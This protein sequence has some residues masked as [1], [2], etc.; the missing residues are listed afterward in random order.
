MPTDGEKLNKY[1]AQLALAKSAALRAG[2]VIRASRTDKNVMVKKGVD[3]VTEIDQRV[4]KLVIDIIREEFP[5]DAIVGE[6]DYSA[7]STKAAPGEK[8]P[9]GKVWCIDPIDGTTNFVHNY[10]FSAVSIGYC[11]DGIPRVGVIYNPNLDAMYEAA[12]GFGAYLN[13]EKMTVDS[14]TSLDDCLLVNN[15]GN[16]RD[17]EF[18]DESTN[19]VNKWL[20]AGLRGYRASG[21]ACQN[22]AH[23]SSGQV[24]CYYEHLYGGPWDV[25]AGTVLVK[26]AGGVVLDPTDGSEFVLKFGKG[27]VCCGNEATVKEVIRVAGFPKYKDS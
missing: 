23:V 22:M 21:S 7:S 24:S 25:C 4:E 10:P 13:G 5:E 12:E 1:A 16:F 20:N 18:I 6:E 26:E 19:R 27:S 14:S 11:E 9:E 3:L 17:K 2:E 15:I 8:I